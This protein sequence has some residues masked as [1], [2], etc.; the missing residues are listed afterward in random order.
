MSAAQENHL[1][2]LAIKIEISFIRKEVRAVFLEAIDY[3]M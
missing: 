3:Q 2:T 1:R